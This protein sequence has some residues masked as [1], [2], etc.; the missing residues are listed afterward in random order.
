VFLI[1]YH[2][3]R[4]KKR[5]RKRGTLDFAWLQRKKSWDLRKEEGNFA[6]AS[7][8]EK[9]KEKE[10][11]TF[12]TIARFKMKTVQGKKKK[13]EGKVSSRREGWG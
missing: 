10:K 13:R 3:P 9:K 6:F 8:G 7:R 12:P 2:W 5:R 11:K 4:G 1:I